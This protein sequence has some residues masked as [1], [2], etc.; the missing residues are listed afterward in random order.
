VIPKKL[1]FNQFKERISDDEQKLKTLVE[2]LFLFQNFCNQENQ[3]KQSH[4]G[5]IP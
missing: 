5:E 2:E 4:F 1:M 3:K